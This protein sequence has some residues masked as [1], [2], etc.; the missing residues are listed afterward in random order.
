ML[1]LD[2]TFGNHLTWH[3]YH[4]YKNILN[5]LVLLCRLQ[6]RTLTYYYLFVRL[7]AKVL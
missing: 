3:I 7:P 6:L 5:T 4:V 2:F 1:A